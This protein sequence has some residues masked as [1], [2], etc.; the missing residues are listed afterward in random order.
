MK[1]KDLGVYMMTS[2]HFNKSA[3]YNSNQSANVI[4][5]VIEIRTSKDLKSWSEPVEVYKDGEKF[6]NHY[7]SIY[8]ASDKDCFCATGNDFVIQLNGNGTDVMQYDAKLVD[9]K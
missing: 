5:R 9:K 1:L 2:S 7:C 8:S 6:G 4:E 3:D